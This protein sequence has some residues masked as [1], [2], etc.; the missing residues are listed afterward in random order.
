MK[1][2]IKRLF[3]LWLLLLQLP[4]CG[5][6]GGEPAGLPEKRNIEESTLQELRNDPDMDY[7]LASP[8]DNLWAQFKSWLFLH[9]VRL[10]G[11]KGTADTLQVI[12]YIICIATLSYA[13][14]RLLNIDASGLFQ[15]KTRQ[16]IIPGQPGGTEENIH[17]IDFKAALAEALQAGAY[18]TAVRLLYLSALKELSTRE[19]IHWQAGKTNYQYQQELNMPQLQAPFRRLGQLFEYAWYGNFSISERHFHQA[20]SMYRSFEQNLKQGL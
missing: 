12:F 10:F 9:F 8:D 6:Q 3:F 16:A 19:L 1:S 14:L 18:N 4:L 20:Q 5:D 7:N 13:I 2:S 17:E 15:A 11:Q